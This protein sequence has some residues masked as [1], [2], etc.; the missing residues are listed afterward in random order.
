MP[1]LC[2]Y[3]SP[4]IVYPKFRGSSRWSGYMSRVFCSFSL[5][6]HRYSRVSVRKYDALPTSDPPPPI[7]TATGV[8]VSGSSSASGTDFCRLA[9]AATSPWSARTDPLDVA[10]TT[11][12]RLVRPV[13]RPFHSDSNFR[14]SFEVHRATTRVPLV[15]RQNFPVT[16]TIYPYTSPC[17]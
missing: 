8:N 9:I 7:H 15:Y 4:N 6:T 14:A 3:V 12:D 1:L 5:C 17:F 2:E 13:H 16:N 10:G 11:F